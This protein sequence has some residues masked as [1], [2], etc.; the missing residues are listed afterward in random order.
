MNQA[1]FN[2]LTNVSPSIFYHGRMISRVMR[3]WI[4][5]CLMF[6]CYIT[7]SL[8]LYQRETLAFRYMF[9]LTFLGDKMNQ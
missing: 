2:G 5:Q 6:L 4:N 9:N 3:S 1:W 8:L 7:S